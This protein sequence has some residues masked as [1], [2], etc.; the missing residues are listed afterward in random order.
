MI[1]RATALL[2]ALALTACATSPPE[3][4]VAPA[5]GE[6]M[7]WILSTEGRDEPALFYGVPESD[8]IVLM[9]ACRRGAGAVEVSVFGSPSQPTKAL[10]LVSGPDTLRRPARAEPSL[11]H[12]EIIVATAP[13]SAAVLA[14][15]AQTGLM[16]VGATARPEPL[17][18]APIATAQAFVDL[19]RS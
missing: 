5:A 6:G 4:P 9:M 1:R 2:G 7:T 11:L 10:Y 8:H 18:R 17:P 19:C 12:D 15:F 16:A 13:A 14:R 3:P